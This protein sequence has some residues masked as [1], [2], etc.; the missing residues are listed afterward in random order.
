M[1]HLG[2]IIWFIATAAMTITVLT[3]GTLASAGWFADATR[4]RRARTHRGRTSR[5]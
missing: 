1:T 4:R 5:R 3:V 2:Y